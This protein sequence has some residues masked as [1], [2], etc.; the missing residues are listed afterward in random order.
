MANFGRFSSYATISTSLMSC[1]GRDYL[2]NKGHEESGRLLN[3]F[4]K[5]SDVIGSNMS[6]YT[7]ALSECNFVRL[8]AYMSDETFP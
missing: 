5:T 6:P 2:V 3:V 1:S 7:E 4:T 8:A